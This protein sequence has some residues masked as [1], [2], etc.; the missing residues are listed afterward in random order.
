MDVLDCC[1]IG[2]FENPWNVLPDIYE[3]TSCYGE[4]VLRWS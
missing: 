1:L 3:A 2:R 4:V